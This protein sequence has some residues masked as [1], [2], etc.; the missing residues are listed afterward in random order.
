MDGSDDG[1]GASSA[2]E[3]EEIH[4]FEDILE[5]QVSREQELDKTP[6]FLR[7]SIH[8]YTYFPNRLLFKMITHP[9]KCQRQ[10][11]FCL[12]KQLQVLP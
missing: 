3:E 5:P 12:T 1:S 11:I 2:G 9:M 6:D 10:D 8:Y 7:P 4:D